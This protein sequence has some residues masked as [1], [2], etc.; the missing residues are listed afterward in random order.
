MKSLIAMGILYLQI[1]V[2]AKEEPFNDLTD[3]VCLVKL[4]DGASYNHDG[5]PQTSMTS[6][7][8]WDFDGYLVETTDEMNF[9]NM[10]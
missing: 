1:F 4:G 3:A 8:D 9:E 7:T 2:S 5:K 10:S 6:T